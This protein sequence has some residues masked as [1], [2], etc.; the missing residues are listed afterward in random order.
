MFNYLF[1]GLSVAF[2]V[3]VAVFLVER[4]KK[5]SVKAVVL[6][7]TSSLFFVVLGCVAIAVKP[8]NFNYGIIFVIGMVFCAVGDIWLDLKY[9]HKE[10]VQKW[11]NLIRGSFTETAVDDLKLGAERPPMPFS[12]T[13]LMGVLNHTLWFLPNVASCY[14]MKNLLV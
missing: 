6:K 13:L 3:C 2:L 8:E 7:A 4:L 5:C 14:A 11:L 1:I 9:V 10:Y 12:D